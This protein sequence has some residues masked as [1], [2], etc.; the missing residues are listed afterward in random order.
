MNKDLGEQIIEDAQEHSPETEENQEIIAGSDGF[1]TEEEEAPAD[2]ADSAKEESEENPDKDEDEK[3]KDNPDKGKEDAP[4]PNKEDERDSRIAELEAELAKSDKRFRDNQGSFTRSQQENAKLKQELADLK[5]EK[6]ADEDNDGKD[7]FDDNPDAE[8]EEKKDK[9]NPEV[10]EK[11]NQRIQNLEADAQKRAEQEAIN[12]W[13]AAEAPVK[14]KHDDYDEIVY[15]TLEPEL[16][17]NPAL[18]EEFQKK[19]ATPEVAYEMG[20]ALYAVRNPEEVKEKLRVEAEKK[21]KTNDPQ[22]KI[23]LSP[24]SQA[25]NGSDAGNPESDIL[26]DV[27]GDR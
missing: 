1:D 26:D 5:A 11:T 8:A 24:N 16:E 21:N 7:W 6:A 27:F 14:E 20:Q 9:N 12:K 10:D 19:G 4:D 2:G 25:P 13:E 23:P 3:D 17:T 18:F 15:K 22:K